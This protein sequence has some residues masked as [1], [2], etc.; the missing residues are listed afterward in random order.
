MTPRTRADSGAGVAQG[1]ALHNNNI[2]HNH[3]TNI[4][5]ATGAGIAL[6]GPPWHNADP[7]FRRQQFGRGG[8]DL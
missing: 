5:V 2:S 8:G 4:I 3:V 6:Q 7:L 1:A